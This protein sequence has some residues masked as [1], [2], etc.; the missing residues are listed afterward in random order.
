MGKLRLELPSLE[1]KDGALEY[2][3]EFSEEGREM[4]GDGGLGKAESYD[5]WVQ[6]K[7]DWHNETNVPNEFVPSSTYFAIRESDDSIVGM[8]DLRHS[9]NDY[10]KKSWNGHIGYAVRKTERRKGYAAE[11][12]KLALKEYKKMGINS[13]IVGCDEDNIGSKKTI[14][15]CGGELLNRSM[16]ED[17]MHLGFEIKLG[18]SK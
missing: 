14:L 7:E 4:S 18:G 3:E 1:R 2:R 16:Q 11:M 13:V 10:L 12:L 15:K 5:E 17:G 8:I 6:Q 9:L